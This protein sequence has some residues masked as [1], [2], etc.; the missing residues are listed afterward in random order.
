M[1]LIIY[2]ECTGGT[3]NINKCPAFPNFAVDACA[4]K[5]H[6]VVMLFFVTAKKGEKIAL[7]ST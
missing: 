1:S 5:G 4:Q 2:T 7:A 6:A 3:E